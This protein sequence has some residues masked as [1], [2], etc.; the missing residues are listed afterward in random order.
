M[1]YFIFNS[2]RKYLRK[3]NDDVFMYN[4]TSLIL[5]YLNKVGLQL[6]I[7]NV[8]SNFFDNIIKKK[9]FI[10]K[11]KSSKAWNENISFI[12]KIKMNLNLTFLLIIY[13]CVISLVNILK[14]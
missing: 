14:K 6:S 3:I 1:T 12:S 9:R 4:V 2:S 10:N 11:S 13:I 5:A 8:N 7:N